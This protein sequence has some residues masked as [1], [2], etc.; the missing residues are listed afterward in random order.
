VAARLAADRAYVDALV[1]GAE[2]VD[3]RLERD[4]LSGIH[5]ANLEQARRPSG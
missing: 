1:R 2:P 5:E 3:R 4:W